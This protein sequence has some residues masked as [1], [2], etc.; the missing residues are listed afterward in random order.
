MRKPETSHNGPPLHT[1]PGNTGR[2]HGP[3]KALGSGTCTVQQVR[4]NAAAETTSSKRVSRPIHDNNRT[5]TQF[6]VVT[7]AVCHRARSSS[8]LIQGLSSHD[9]RAG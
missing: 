3:A 9:T 5:D 2:T 8:T 4:M 7:S 1:P 6:Y